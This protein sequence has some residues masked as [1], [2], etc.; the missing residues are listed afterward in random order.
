MAEFQVFLLGDDA[1]AVRPDDKLLR[2]SLA[3]SL[4]DIGEWT[5]VV[6]GKEVVA[7]QFDP[8]WLKP[9]DAVSRLEVWLEEFRPGTE[10]AGKR[11]T[12]QLDAAD[13]NAPDLAALAEQN[14]LSPE[15]FLARVTQSDL[16]VDMLG[17]TP[18]FAYVEGVD[19]ALHAER[20]AVP[21]QRVKAGSVGIVRGQ[22]GL[23]ALS[24]PGGWPI[25][26]RLTEA[27]FDP[28]RENPF[29]LEEGT[30]IR[31]ELVGR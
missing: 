26:G 24:G 10:G 17:F 20:L 16:I 5:N 9:E 28:N 4:R 31:L 13:C 27:L 12:L 2:H 25:I 30:R 19:P 22:L 3:R 1:V 29:L 7:V 11:V 18:G 15:T 23:Y 21:R 8:S 6:P 14:G